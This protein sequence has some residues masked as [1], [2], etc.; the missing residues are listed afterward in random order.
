MPESVL[1]GFVYVENSSWFQYI[2]A[3]DGQKLV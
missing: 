1:T 2:L 3:Y